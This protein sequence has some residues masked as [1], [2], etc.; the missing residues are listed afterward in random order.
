MI[1]KLTRSL[2]TLAVVLSFATQ[3]CLAESGPTFDDLGLGADSTWNGSD[4]SGGF[5]SEGFSFNNTYDTTWGSWA[6]WAGSTMTDSTTAGWG[7][8][9]SAITGAGADGSSAYGVAYY[10]AWGPTVPTLSIADGRDVPDGLFVTNTTYA[11]FSMKDGDGFVDPF[12][13]NDWQTLTIVGKSGAA[14]VGSVDV[15]LADGTTILDQWS[16]VDLRGLQGQSVDTLDFTFAGSQ[17][18]MT[19]TYVAVDGLAPI[20]EPSTLVM[21]LTA[22]M[23]LLLWRRQ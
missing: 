14:V 17:I 23:A 22:A 21:I 20:P 18:D 6:G 1:L 16:W 13:P 2:V 4:E 7:N 15:A 11:Y 5:S 8:Q 9:F 3:S 19:P 12:G 10:D